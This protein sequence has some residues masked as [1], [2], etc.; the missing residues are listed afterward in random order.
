M[1]ITFKHEIK[2]GDKITDSEILKIL[3]KNR[4]IKDKKEF[5]NPVSPLKISLSYFGFK[6]EIQKTLKYL[7]SLKEHNK[8]IVV[9]TDYDADGITGGA[10][11]WETLHLL[12]FK[13]MPY[14][15]HRKLEG[16][17]FSIK[18]IDA[19]KKL[20]NPSLVISVDHGITAKEKVTYAK[21]LGIPII[22]TD[23]HLKP[24]KLPDDAFAIF[25]IP[26]LSG[27]GV[28]YFFAKEIFDNFAHQTSAVKRKR[29]DGKTAEVKRLQK[30]FSSDYLALASIGAV[31]DLVPLIGP[32]RSLVKH[33]L[34]SFSDLKRLG[35][36]H[37]IKE[38][39]ILGRVIT[40]YEVGFIIAPRIN[41]VGRLEH[42]IDA[43]RLLCTTDEKRAHSL[44][45]QIGDHNRQ[46]Q[47]MVTS[48][49]E[50]A[51]KMVLKSL[52]AKYADLKTL[53]GATEP[54][55]KTDSFALRGFSKT[56]TS[57]QLPKIIILEN[58]KWHEGIIGLIAS[59]ICEEFYRPTIVLTESDGFL[60]GS[61]RS[62]ASF[63]I[64][65]FLRDLKEF[66]IDVGGHKGAA[67]FTMEKSKF[68]KF[69][70]TAQKKAEK[71][72]S[73]K[74]LERTI[75]VDLKSSISQISPKLVKA[76]EALEPFGIGNPRPTF[77]SQAELVDAKLF[78]KTNN[79]LKLFVKDPDNNSLPLELI[80]FSNGDQFNK[81][82]RG[83]K[84]EIVYSLE[85]DRWGGGEKMRG[86]VINFL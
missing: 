45:S 3:L 22:I 29:Y 40:T 41:A 58:R 35:L 61:A 59:K 21:K 80:S 8:M 76:M 60:K 71:L 78:G 1:K 37:I 32:T 25:H 17:G 15:P 86:K 52:G 9:Y 63:H 74:D 16:Y 64:T 47:D 51:K 26:E 4:G 12:G 50:E 49:V 54:V 20:H 79:H 70:Q 56:H 84:L 14:V 34:N 7:K 28:A 30:N 13:V 48:A 23:H 36:K 24:D 68:A 69:V 77:F 42:A 55:D 31:A 27:A 18:S 44:A 65:N 46:R 38:A 11:L 73:E 6:E 82:S 57:D 39:G 19:V 81:F 5:L 2:S 72:I 67:G 75:E 83:Q 53:N 33:G 43:L 10:I 66:L 62:I 85:I